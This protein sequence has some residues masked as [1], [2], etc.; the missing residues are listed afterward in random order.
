MA[1]GMITV[2]TTG[3]FKNMKGFFQ[4]TK[5][6]NFRKALEQYGRAGVEILASETPV[7]TGEASSSWYYEIVEHKGSISLLW[8]N[9]AMAGS[10]P[11]VILIKYGHGTGNG[12]YVQPNDFISPIV[13]DLFRSMA[14]TIWKEVTET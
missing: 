13:A 12:G 9:S 1:S 3:S 5:R 4:R 8:R 7:D 11:V 14:D 6:K 2:E 10:T